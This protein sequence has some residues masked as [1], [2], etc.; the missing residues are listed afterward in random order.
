MIGI[1]WGLIANGKL[2]FELTYSNDQYNKKTIKAYLDEFK[3]NLLEIIDYCCTY[4]Q[5]ELTPSDLTYKDLTISQLDELQARYKIEDIYR[6]SPL[7]EGILFHAL[8]DSESLNYFV[9]FNY[10]VKGKINLEVLRESLNQLIS[11]HA[12][13]RTIFLYEGYDRP[14]QLVMKEREV[15]F[16]FKNIQQ[17]CLSEAPADVLE[18]YR[19]KDLTQTFN[20]EEDALMRITILQ[21]HEDEFEFIWSFH[22]ILMDGWCMGIIINEFGVIYSQMLSGQTVN[23]PSA[24][25][26]SEYIKWLEKRD[27]ARSSVYW[28]NYLTGYDSLATLPKK[29]FQSEGQFFNQEII[30]LQ[31]EKSRT[32]LLQK[33]S[34]KNQVTINT[35]IQAAWGILLSK[36]NNTN[37]VVFGSVVS[38][39]PAEIEGIES[40]VGLFVNTIPV[41][42]TFTDEDYIDDLLKNIQYLAM[43]SEPYHYHPLAEISSKSDLGRNLLDHIVAFENYPIAKELEG[44]NNIQG[45]NNRGFE[46]TNVKIFEQT[47]YDLTIVVTPGEELSVEFR[48]NSN[49]YSKQT[50]NNISKHLNQ[51]LEHICS[52]S[53]KKIVDL[54]I[55]T[56]E[57]KCDLLYKFN[58]TGVN[59]P[60]DKT[61]ID[62]FEAQVE[63]TPENIALTFSGSSLTYRELNDK[64][65]QLAYQLRIK[66]VRPDSIV[67]LLTHRS[68]ETI[69]GM[70]SVLKAGGAYMPIDADYPVE[71]INYLISD[72]KT[73]LVLTTNDLKN[74]LNSDVDVIILD[75]KENYSE[76]TSNPEKINSQNDLC[77]IIYTSGTTGLPKG[78]M[79][80]HKNVVRLLFNEKFQFDFGSDDVWTMFHSHCFDFSVWEM[81]GALLFGGKLIIVPKIIAQE[82]SEYL[83]LLKD[84]K[85][86]IL[87]QTPSAFYNLIQEDLESGDK[88]LQLK[89]VI[90]GGEALKPGKLKEWNKKYPSTKLINMFGITETTVHVTYKEIGLSEIENNIS[91]IGKPIPTLSAYVLDKHLRIIPQGVAGELFVGGDG[92]ARG[93]LGKEE[94]TKKRFITNPYNI[95]ERLYCT[96]DLVRILMNG[97]L[98]YLGRI[99]HQIQLRGF[100]IELG[101]I[102]SQLLNYPLIKDV[103]VIDREDNEG[104]VS[105]CAY[106]VAEEK[107]EISGIRAYLSK[108][109]P[110]YMV[111][112]YFVQ[113]NTLPLTSNGKIDRK[114]LPYPVIDSTESYVAPRNE[115]EKDL[116]EIWSDVLNVKKVGIT[117]NFFSL[118]GDSIVAIRLISAINKTLN[119]NIKISDLFANQSIADLSKCVVSDNDD[120]IS[121]IS[122]EI[123][124]EFKNIKDIF[125][126]KRC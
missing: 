47:N 105:L 85:V 41:R 36:Y 42:I 19:K 5:P 112:S 3:N 40:I 122:K 25:S 102:E 90:F 65:N 79:V 53:N 15:D 73:K 56:E 50:I 18:D 111:P 103:V 48:Y 68:F 9:Q 11:R 7:Q 8:Y 29:E 33:V 108:M 82:P 104:N 99:D 106:L 52:L 120:K 83:N 115:L 118:G 72:S 17:E 28:Q 23:M 43:E 58:S 93:Y 61:I 77:Y 125:L 91:N 78:V 123:E 67:G 14:I 80:E 81:Y 12:T 75:S 119:T 124:A 22:H 54:E 45:K 109:L 24:I 92:V 100:R 44:L 74:K 2:N 88:K 30:K 107:V 86:T 70:L 114:A 31:I 110:D 113:L 13:L 121:D 116:T 84:N 46:V 66:N 32:S 94:L 89:Y 6:L 16:T 55:V 69:I 87:N 27:K 101:E 60:K 35:I 59:Y 4:A 126:F 37:D 97:E 49:K 64:S 98:E 76:K 10:G 57:E 95:A 26:Y 39:R 1:S 38:G 20:L 63:K 62:L 51:I 21:T 117:D 71:R 34:G 96:G